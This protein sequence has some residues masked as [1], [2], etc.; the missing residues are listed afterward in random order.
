MLSKLRFYC[1]VEV[2]SEI[3]SGCEDKDESGI[4]PDW[5]VTIARKL[6]WFKEAG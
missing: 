3:S 5:A 6:N 4:D 1:A 2:L